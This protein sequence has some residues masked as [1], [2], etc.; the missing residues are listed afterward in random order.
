MGTVKNVM[1]HLPPLVTGTPAASSPLGGGSIC[2][3]ELRKAVIAGAMQDQK[4]VFENE[5]ESICFFFEVLFVRPKSK[6]SIPRWVW[7]WVWVCGALGG[8]CWLSSPSTEQ[9]GGCVGAFEG[10][11]KW[12]N[13]QPGTLFSLVIQRF[14]ADTA[15]TPTLGIHI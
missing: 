8:D 15:V 2:R 12:N 11:A 6:A 10:F 4:C 13:P 3:P 1:T 14:R 5:R 7:V 9:R